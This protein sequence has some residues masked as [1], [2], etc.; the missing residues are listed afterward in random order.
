MECCQIGWAEIQAI[1][2]R[3]SPLSAMHRSHWRCKSNQ[4]KRTVGVPFLPC[5][6]KGSTQFFC[7]AP[8]ERR[9]LQ[10]DLWTQMKSFH[11]RWYLCK[12]APCRSST[13]P[14]HWCTRW[15]GGPAP[16]SGR[17]RRWTEPQL[18]HR[19][20]GRWWR[21]CRSGGKARSSGHAQKLEKEKE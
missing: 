13:D 19:R 4:K 2:N 6:T 17:G 12:Q 18:Q 11:P 8:T 16:E 7:R 3:L 10:T 9:R 20:A 14:S 1:K 5:L 15:Q 21:S